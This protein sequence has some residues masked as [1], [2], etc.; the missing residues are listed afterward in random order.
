MRWKFNNEKTTREVHKII[1]QDF[2]DCNLTVDSNLLYIEHSNGPLY[3]SAVNDA[4]RGCGGVLV[5]T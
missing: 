1:S 5:T 4:I 3:D 2:P